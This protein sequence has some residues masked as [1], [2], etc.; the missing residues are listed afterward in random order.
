TA[1]LGWTGVRW[2]AVPVPADRARTSRR[3][4]RWPSLQSRS[5]CPTADSLTVSRKDNASWQIRIDFGKNG[6]LG[7]GGQ[8]LPPKISQSLARKPD[9]AGAGFC[10]GILE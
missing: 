7:P 10:F 8:T 3:G 1:R 6:F 5:A 4:P 9:T 2:S